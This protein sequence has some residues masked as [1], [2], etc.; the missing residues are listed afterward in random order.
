MKMF[1]KRFP[2]LRW[3][4]VISTAAALAA[5]TVGPDYKAPAIVEP[6]VKGFQETQKTQ[7]L[8]DGAVA[9]AW[10]ELYQDPVLNRLIQDAFEH[11]PN[12]GH[13]SANLKLARAQL[14]EAGAD[15]LPSTQV[16]AR[17]SRER[18]G[19][20]NEA[21]TASRQGGGGGFKDDSGDFNYYKTGFD[22]SYEV[23]VFGR[24]SRSIE[25]AQGDAQVA[26]ANLHSARISIAA[27]V[28][29]SYADA[30]GFAAQAD[31]ARE[32]ARIE[33]STR[34]V[35]QNL[36]QL[37][38]STSR[39]LDQATVLVEQANAQVPVLEGERRAHLYALA[40]LTGHTPAELD[41]QASACRAVPKVDSP[42]P[43]GDG[44][45][46][47]ARRPDVRAAERKLAADTARIGV[48]TAALYPSISLM[49]STTLGAPKLSN[50]G[51]SESFGYS[52]GP[53]ISWSFPN[54]TAVRAR[55]N[56]SKAGADASLA[57]FQG[58]M[59][60]AL[61]ETE[62]SL[63]RYAAAVDEN[64]SL[65]LAERAATDAAQ[66]TRTRYDAGRDTFVELLVAEQNRAT[67]RGAL[68]RSDTNVANLQIAL[69]KA[70][71]GGWEQKEAVIKTKSAT[72][73]AEKD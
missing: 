5:C 21:T 28:A 27:Q 52:F 71:G 66:V 70:L 57:N 62:Q 7:L 40:A 34:D 41:S 2:V 42:I 69:F 11:N 32:T 14:S 48:A 30:C 6:A 18:V 72:Q 36:M 59:L 38:R 67:T 65:S 17:Y 23:D 22:A 8:G 16:S 37:G 3:L 54:F 10:W 46:L 50:M 26:E 39:D 33:S 73:V 56:Q 49:G 43:V 47:L 64:R 63:A 55:I 12:I 45:A 24:V 1:Q 53:L 20:S 4:G 13:A 25:A 9:S 58:V 68:A 15:R 35:T 31:V 19:S 51:K 60:N 44:A 61:K 29:Q